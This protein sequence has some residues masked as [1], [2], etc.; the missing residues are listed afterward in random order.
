MGNIKM[1]DTVS[2]AIVESPCSGSGLERFIIAYRTEQSLHLRIYAPSTRPERRNL[3]YSFDEL[4]GMIISRRPNRR[5]SSDKA[6]GPRHM[7]ATAITADKS[8]VIGIPS[9]PTLNA[10]NKEKT[11]AIPTRA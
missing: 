10:G 5:A 3:S 4:A 11:L 2:Y 8:A 1:F 7:T 6:P 9:G